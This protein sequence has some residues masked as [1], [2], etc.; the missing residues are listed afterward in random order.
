MK[1]PSIKT[2]RLLLR[3]QLLEDLATFSSMNKDPR[4]M[5]FF[6]ATMTQEQSQR[7]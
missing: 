4:V 6:P 3:P 5:E 1:A 7:S 2:S